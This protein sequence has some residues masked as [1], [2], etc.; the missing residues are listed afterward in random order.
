MF[1]P[2]FGT[3]PF[4]PL[5]ALLLNIA[6]GGPRSTDMRR[7]FGGGML[8]GSLVLWLVLLWLLL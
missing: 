6:G 5:M 1:R 8:T 2:V 7:F 3:L 4:I